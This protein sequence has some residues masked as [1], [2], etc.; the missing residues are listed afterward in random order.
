MQ[1][2]GACGN[3]QLRASAARPKEVRKI[4]ADTTKYQDTTKYLLTAVA[5]TCWILVKLAPSH[6]H[7]Q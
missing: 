7:Q 6:H 3:L 5:Q 2:S 1:T 4:L